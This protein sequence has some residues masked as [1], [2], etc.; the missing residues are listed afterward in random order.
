V[1]GRDEGGEEERERD[2]EVAHEVSWIV[3]RTGSAVRGEERLSGVSW[4]LLT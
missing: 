3:G 2:R 4:K 1:R